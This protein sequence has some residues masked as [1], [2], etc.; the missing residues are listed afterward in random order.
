MPD[1]TTPDN[2]AGGNNFAVLRNVTALGLLIERVKNR[3]YGLPGMACFYGPSGYGKSM[4]S[5]WCAN[6]YDAKL[7]QVKSAWTSRKLCEAI[8]IELG[9]KPRGSIADMIDTISERLG[10]TETPLIIDE[11]D[12]LAKHGMIEHVRDIYE[13][14]QVPVILIGEELLPQTLQ[15]WER[16][17]G[18]MLDWIAA[19]P[20]TRKDVD[21]LAG[22][23]CRGLTIDDALKDLL[24]KH[25]HGSIRRVVVNLDL[26][27][28]F[29][30]REGIATVTRAAW[31]GT[32]FPTGLAPEARR[33]AA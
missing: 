11:A 31:G 1:E 27:R 15:R 10:V 22:L 19:Q 3:S 21:Q 14:C 30:A 28:E 25:A 16:V 13:S 26:V 8:L 20:A 24:L 29:A 32:V 5:T 4:A 33:A 18:R 17:H 23:Y 2:R 9:V 12:H 6:R 7:V